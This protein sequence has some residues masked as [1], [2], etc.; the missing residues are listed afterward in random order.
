MPRPF[1][2]SQPCGRAISATKPPV[3]RRGMRCDV[4]RAAAAVAARLLIA[5]CVVASAFSPRAALAQGT[6]GQLPDPMATVD[7]KRLMTMYVHPTDAE[8]ASIEA[9]HDDYRAKFRVLRD[10]EIEG[11]LAEAQSLMGAGVPSKSKVQDFTKKYERINAQIAE[12]DN[13]FFD[14]VGT[15]LGEDR[16]VGVKR[17]RDARSRNRLAMGFLGE[18]PGMFGRS[19]PDVAALSIEAKLPAALMAE[20]QPELLAYEDKLTASAKE[21]ATAGMHMMLELVESL[22]KAGFGG[23]GE[24]EMAADPERMKGMMEAV[25]TAM[26]TAMKPI[27]DRSAAIVELNNQT[28]RN[29]HARLSGDEAR[30]FRVRYVER[31]YPE[32]GR[33]PS[34]T[35]HLLTLALRIRSLDE[36]A[37]SSIQSAYESWKSADDKLVDEAMKL[38]DKNRKEL[39]GLGFGGM[40]EGYA[41]IAEY[42]Q[43]RAELGAKTLESVKPLLGDERLQKLFAKVSEAQG[44]PFDDT[45]DPEAVA[46][47][48]AAPAVGV[49]AGAPEPV[50]VAVGTSQVPPVMNIAGLRQLADDLGL[51]AGGKAAMESMFADYEKKWEEAVKPFGTRITESQSGMWMIEGES[52]TI[53]QEKREAYFNLRREAAKKSIELDDALFHDL[54][55]VVGQEKAAI[56]SAIRL[57]RMLEVDATVSTWR[58]FG[59]WQGAQRA[60]N[61]VQAVRDADLAPE[62]RARVLV[63]LGERA[64]EAYKSFHESWLRGIDL[65]R[66]MQLLNERSQSL[67]RGGQEADPV[68][69]QNAGRDWMKLQARIGAESQRGTDALQSIWDAAVATLEGEPRSRL[70]LAYDRLAYPDI[71]EDPHN[72]SPLIEH[73]MEL[74]DLSDDQRRELQVLRDRYHEE[75][76]GFCRKMILKPAAQPEDM[77]GA[78]ASEYWKDR[79]AQ[80]NAK[81]KVRFDRDERSQRAVSQLRRILN[82]EQAGRISGLAAYDKQFETNRSGPVFVE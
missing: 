78:K 50:E 12:I 82:A 69:A 15:L 34:N 59:G 67:Y 26:Q 21:L 14:G 17:A 64:G 47:G 6:S 5:L 3:A 77:D 49:R 58:M 2:R 39:S 55:G 37:R 41:K 38:A 36:S 24:E 20:L 75:Y 63:A 53:N 71:F 44:D 4:S 68:E 13:A 35:E 60:V 52:A 33:D 70:T 1:N 54:A 80:E 76:V 32:I 62:E 28:F 19:T 18:L 46:E 9:L 66:E 22:E 57:G 74:P 43:K 23:M 40:N 81:N 51:D 42:G 29:V 30:K 48:T 31:A 25:Q 7:V 79:M 73:A 11:F 45:S 65:D 16:Q 72:A 61:V 56:L 8:M 27:A 10:N